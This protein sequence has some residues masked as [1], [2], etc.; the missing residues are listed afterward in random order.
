MATNSDRRSIRELSSTTP[1]FAAANGCHKTWPVPRA[2]KSDCLGGTDH[3]YVNATVRSMSDGV[4]PVYAE[5][6]R[7]S[8][9]SRVTHTPPHSSHRQYWMPGDKS[10]RDSWRT[11]SDCLQ[12]VQKGTTG[13]G[14]CAKSRNGIAA[15]EGI[16][17]RDEARRNAS[18]S[19]L[20]QSGRRNCRLG[21][22]SLSIRV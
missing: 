10:S 12:V 14:V 5:A 22:T 8:S 1:L 20:A 3:K 16:D 4:P 17:R 2:R 7:K 19:T 21:D 11:R 9:P 18:A 13:P 6:E 15:S